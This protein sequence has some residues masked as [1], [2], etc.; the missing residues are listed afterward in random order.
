MSF[1]LTPPVATTR[2]EETHEHML[3]VCAVE[4]CGRR[5]Q[6]PEGHPE[7]SHGFAFAEWRGGVIGYRRLAATFSNVF[8]EDMLKFASEEAHQH[9]SW[10]QN[11]W[12]QSCVEPQNMWPQSCLEP[13]NVYHTVPCAVKHFATELLL[14]HNTFVHRV[15][16]GH[17]TCWRSLVFCR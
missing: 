5:R 14:G 11:M 2:Q 4:R 10:T 8:E 13:Q 9:D 6:A 17:K 12:P 7:T 1:G 15:A 16:S 3:L